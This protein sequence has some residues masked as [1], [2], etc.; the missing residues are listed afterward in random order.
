MC[1]HQIKLLSTVKQGLRDSTGC[2]DAGGCFSTE[3]RIPN[4]MPV[5]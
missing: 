3:L 4:G 5:E 2:D 1:Q